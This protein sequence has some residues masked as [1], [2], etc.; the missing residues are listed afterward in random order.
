MTGEEILMAHAV[1]VRTAELAIMKAQGIILDYEIKGDVKTGMIDVMV[2]PVA[3]IP[4]VY[5]DINIK[6]E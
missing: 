3:A 4:H 1:S 5:V 2:R 6:K